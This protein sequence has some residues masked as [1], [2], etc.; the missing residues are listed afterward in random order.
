[1][2]RYIDDMGVRREATPEEVA[3]IEAREAEASIIKV[4]ESVP[5]RKAFK[6]MRRTEW[7][8]GVSLYTH[9]I[10]TINAIPDEL[11]RDDAMTDF[12]RSLYF[13]RHS[14]QTLTL[15][16]M[17]GVSSEQLDALFIDANALE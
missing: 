2:T 6:I 13:Q 16:A 4:P 12:M 17:A 8:P 9:L 1:M 14:S 10:N 7:S 11:L 15:A 3:D 5:C